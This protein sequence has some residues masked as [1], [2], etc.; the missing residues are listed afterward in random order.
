MLDSAQSVWLDLTGRLGQVSH[1]FGV[2]GSVFPT[3]LSIELSQ[4]RCGYM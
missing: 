2:H 1:G 4:S 3:L